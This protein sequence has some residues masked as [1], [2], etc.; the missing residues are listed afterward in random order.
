MGAD[1]DILPPMPWRS[2]AALKDDD[3]KAIYAYLRTIRPSGTR[4]QSLFRPADR[5][6]WNNRAKRVSAFSP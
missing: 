1:R 3:L 2:L 5:L 4:C 6:A